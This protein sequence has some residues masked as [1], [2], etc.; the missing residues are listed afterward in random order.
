MRS[1][2][3]SVLSRAAVLLAALVVVVPAAQAQVCEGDIILETQADVD[4]FACTEV[5]GNLIIESGA[6]DPITSLTG[7][8]SLTRA[9]RIFISL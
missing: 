1:P 2:V 6:T 8:S 3:R 4:A 5:T 9:V 7:L